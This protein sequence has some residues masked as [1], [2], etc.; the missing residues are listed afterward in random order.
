MKTDIINEHKE[1]L[2]NRYGIKCTSTSLIAM[3]LNVQIT[4]NVLDPLRCIK[5]QLDQD[6][7]KHQ[8]NTH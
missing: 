8:Q 1:Y 6:L 5:I 7:L 2:P 4:F 3:V